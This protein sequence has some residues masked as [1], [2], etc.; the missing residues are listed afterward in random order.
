MLLTLVG[1]P[2][3]E[4][5]SG[6]KTDPGREVCCHDV[7]QCHHTSFL[8]FMGRWDIMRWDQLTAP[9]LHNLSFLLY[10][11]PHNSILV[12]T[13]TE[14]SIQDSFILSFLVFGLAVCQGNYIALSKSRWVWGR[15]L[16]F[17]NILTPWKLK[18]PETPLERAYKCSQGFPMK[19]PT[20]HWTG[21]SFLRGK[22]PRFGS[23][24]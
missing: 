21:L 9:R 2:S 19:V 22:V 24:F 3:L 14:Y 15:S 7:S 20:R 17:S 13:C 6:W 8:L 23:C 12:W 11:L 18:Q 10:L 4:S 5:L 1:L 16:I